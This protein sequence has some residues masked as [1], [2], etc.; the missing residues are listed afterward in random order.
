MG[1][2]QARPDHQRHYEELAQKTGFST[3]QIKN[4]HKR[5]QQLS[6]NQET[7]SR[8]NLEN[9]PALANNP[10]KK[11]IIDAFFD[12]RNQQDGES[13]CLEE[14][15]LG[16][17]LMVMSHFRPPQHKSS[18]DE[19]HAIRRQKLRFLFNMHDTDSDGTITLAEYRKVVEEL[20][21]KSGAIGH[22][23]AKIIADAAMLEV[24]STNVPH[25]APDEFYEGI[26][27]EHFEQILNGLE[28]ESRMHIRFLDVATT[29]MRC[30]KGSSSSTY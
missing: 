13:G 24:A 27:F 21:S 29:T 16:H 12:K 6:G 20:L 7:I 4:L 28:M 10:I 19:R 1:S 2:W 15:T 8:E 17:F 3:E 11:Q 14:I 18:E 23:A 26:T 9:I 30:G 5:F 25:M 22:E